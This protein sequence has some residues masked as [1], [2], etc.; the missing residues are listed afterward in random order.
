MQKSF[1]W[2]NTIEENYIVKL[3]YADFKYFFILLV[4]SLPLLDY[5]NKWNLSKNFNIK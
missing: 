1:Y 4:V 2:D 3:K 5:L